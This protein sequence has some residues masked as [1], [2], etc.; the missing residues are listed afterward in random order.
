MAPFELLQPTSIAEAV[1]LLDAQDAR[2]LSGGTALMLMMKAGV[3]RPQRLVSLRKLGLDRI[4]ANG[5]LRIGAM[6]SLRSLELS[7]EIKR[8]WPVN[9]AGR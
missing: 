1:R 3:L 8:G 2:P 9:A 7:D 6:A 5:T 4:E